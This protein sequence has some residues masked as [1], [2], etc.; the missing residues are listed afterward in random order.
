[1]A[2]KHG[3]ILHLVPVMMKVRADRQAAVAEQDEQRSQTV[4]I[5]LAGLDHCD[6]LLPG[7]HFPSFRRSADQLE[8]D[9]ILAS[10]LSLICEQAH[11]LPRILPPGQSV[12]LLLI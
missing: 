12:P 8:A 4:G 2:R 9:K 5:G 7:H 6:A 11:S 10:S 3:K 1:G